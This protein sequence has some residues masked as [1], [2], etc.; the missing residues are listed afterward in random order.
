MMEL[1]DALKNNKGTVSSSL[2]K[3]LANEILHGNKKILKEAV[4]YVCYNLKNKGDKNVRS[5]AAK[6][7][8]CVAQ[9]DSKLIAQ[10]LGKL[11]PALNVNEPQTRWMIFRTIGFCAKLRPE[12]AKSVIPYAKQYIREK[13]DGQLCLVSSI[14]LFL[15]DYGSISKEAK[16]E[17]YPILLESIDN[18]I[19]NEHDWIIESLIKIS[20][21]FN[22]EEK[23]QICSFAN[24][25]KNYTRKKTQERV[26]ILLKKCE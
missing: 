15:G 22:K 19:Q 14:D 2:G 4:P 11:V 25:Y 3:E 20:Q 18:I 24:E 10:Y 8:E 17:V 1:F 6:I 13:V 23:K 9:E 12:I 21:Y 16:E 5:G 7:I 26:L